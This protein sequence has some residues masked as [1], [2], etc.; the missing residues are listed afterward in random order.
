M[1]A[2]GSESLLSTRLAVSSAT[3]STGD[4]RGEDNGSN[5]PLLWEA[6]M[7]SSS[8]LVSTNSPTIMPPMHKKYP[9]SFHQGSPSISS[10][11]ITADKLFDR[12]FEPW[13]TVT[14]KRASYWRIPRAM[15]GTLVIAKNR[16]P[17]R[18]AHG[19]QLLQVFPQPPSKHSLKKTAT[20]RVHHMLPASDPEIAPREKPRMT[21]P[22]G[23]CASTRTFTTNHETKIVV[24]ARTRHRS[25]TS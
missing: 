5:W 23:Q 13:K 2:G 6:L 24:Y 19:S 4:I 12:M 18:S 3:S 11:T 25:R 20:K 7:R 21:E 17:A 8:P 15:Y 10:S 22:C 16:A 14:M 9:A 1:K